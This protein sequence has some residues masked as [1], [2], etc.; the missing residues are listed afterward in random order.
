[1]DSRGRAVAYTT[2]P[3]LASYQ[4]HEDRVTLFQ[5]VA[6]GLLKVFVGC[7][8]VPACNHGDLAVCGLQHDAT[9]PSS[10]AT[11]AVAVKLP[12]GWKGQEGLQGVQ[13]LLQ[14]HAASASHNVHAEDYAQCLPR[15]LAPQ[16]M[17]LCWLMRTM[18]L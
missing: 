13:E 9:D 12:V 18:Q 11:L 4:S 10:W 14:M 3:L 8:R 17:A 5:E 16:C 15:Y 7:R 6:V 1:M 2:R